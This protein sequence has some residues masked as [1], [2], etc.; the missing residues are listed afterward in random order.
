MIKYNHL[1]LRISNCR[2]LRSEVTKK[3]EVLCMNIYTNSNVQAIISIN[4]N[5]VTGNYDINNMS[6]RS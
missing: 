2:Y 4:F 1:I 3:K 6:K 5:N